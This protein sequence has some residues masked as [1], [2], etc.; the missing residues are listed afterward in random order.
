MSQH[1]VHV[2]GAASC[3]LAVAIGNGMAA[4]KPTVSR[5]EQCVRLNRQIDTV[6]SGPNVAANQAA[7]AKLLQKNGQ[8]LCA[9]RKQA[10]GIRAFANALK[11]LGEKPADA[12]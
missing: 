12:D 9:S 5:N 8:D 10:Q 1:F 7:A 2:F 6:L 3:V 4:T 11:L